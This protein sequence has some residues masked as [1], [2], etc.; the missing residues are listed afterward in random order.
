MTKIKFIDARFADPD[1]NEFALKRRFEWHLR[2]LRA[3]QDGVSP[4]VPGDFEDEFAGTRTSSPCRSRKR[5]GTRCCA[6]RARSWVRVERLPG[7]AILV[8][9]TGARSRRSAARRIWS[10]STASTAPMRS[11]RPFM[12]R[13]PGW[14][15]PLTSSGRRCVARCGWGARIPSAA[16]AARWPAGDRQER[17]VT[18]TRAPSRGAA[19]WHRG[20]RR[21]G[22]VRCQWLATRLALGLP[23]PTSADH[24]AE[25]CAS[26]I[27]VIDEIEKAG[28]PTSTK[29][30]A[31]AWPT[32]CCRCWSARLPWHGSV[33]IIRSASTCPGSA[34]S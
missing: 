24:R 12:P 25:L 8:R 32:G 13:C 21:T 3:L 33:P 27:V 4:K 2:K 22:L 26:P 10:A 23:G 17:V 11:L 29:G 18:R 6:V 20:N 34:G 16:R 9:M 28:T 19:L 5:T 1:E 7:S 15:R 14:R 30:Q 31:T